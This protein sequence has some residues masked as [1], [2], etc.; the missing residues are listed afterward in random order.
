M[1]PQTQWLW[2]QRYSFSGFLGWLEATIILYVL[3]ATGGRC[4]CEFQGEGAAPTQGGAPP[5]EREDKRKPSFSNSSRKHLLTH[6]WP[7][8]SHMT[9]LI[10]Y[11]GERTFC[12]GGRNCRDTWQ[13][14]GCEEGREE[15][16]AAR[17]LRF[18][19]A[20]NRTSLPFLL[21]C[22]QVKHRVA[23]SRHFNQICLYSQFPKNTLQMNFCYPIHFNIRSCL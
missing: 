16:E 21:L 13:R 4:M 2:K 20:G 9:S 11:E 18:K 8:A 17:P 10:A 1:Q 22:L 14:A 5:T 7:R 6:H 19:L 3:R 15:P 12:L 23:L